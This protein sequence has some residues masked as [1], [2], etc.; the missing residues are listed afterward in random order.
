MLYKIRRTDP[1]VNVWIYSYARMTDKQLGRR[2]TDATER[3]TSRIQERQW[4]GN[5]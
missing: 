4:K 2:Q 3:I 5:V 1:P